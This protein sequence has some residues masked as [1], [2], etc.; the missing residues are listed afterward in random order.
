MLNPPASRMSKLLTIDDARESLRAHVAAKGAELR[1]K[2][3]PSIGWAELQRLLL[4]REFVRYPCEIVFDAGELREG[5]FAC[6]LPKGER[7]E[8][9]FKMCV[10]S[11][12]ATQLE[13]VPEMVLYQLVAVNYGEFACA[14]DA[15]TFGSAALGMSVEAYYKIL[16]KIADEISA[17]PS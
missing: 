4:D 6:P 1:A 13:R 10:H 15:E 5:E 9:G 8:A 2:Y 7:P 3:G 12:F 16:C 17:C 11:Y 14:S